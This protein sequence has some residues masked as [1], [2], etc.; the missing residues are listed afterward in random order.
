M[1]IGSLE[2]IAGPMFSGKTEQLIHSILE[3]IQESLS[4]EAFKPCLDDRHPEAFIVSHAGSRYAAKWVQGADWT[5]TARALFLDEVQ[6]FP[7]GIVPKVKKA[8]RQGHRVVLAGLDLTSGEEPFP[9]PIQELLALADKV[10][11]LQAACAC[12]RPATRSQRIVPAEGVILVGGAE[13]YEPRC[14]RCFSP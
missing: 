2:V 6:F 8:V 4:V 13:S 7:N 5:Y 10:T 11:K 1:Q 14:L 9:G 12:G 3:A